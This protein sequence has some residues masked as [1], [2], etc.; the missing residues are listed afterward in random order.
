[1]NVRD[2]FGSLR[3]LAEL[4][5]PP[6]RTE[7]VADVHRALSWAGRQTRRSLENVEPAALRAELEM[8]LA[9]LERGVVDHPR[10]A[11]GVHFG[12]LYAVVGLKLGGGAILLG[13]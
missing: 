11:A 10:L 3:R 12:D 7:V 9:E 2:D 4:D 1:M 8:K 13:G 5:A 6:E